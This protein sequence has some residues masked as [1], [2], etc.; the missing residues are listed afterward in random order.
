MRDR[1]P[2]FDEEDL[3]KTLTEGWRIEPVILEYAPVGFGDYHW[4]A[5]SAAG[6]RWFVKV[7]DLTQ[8]SHC[9]P[10]PVS[11]AIGLERAMDTAAEL[12]LRP[13]LAFVAGPVRGVDGRSV[14]PSGPR[15]AVSVF[16]HLDA[17]PGSFDR[18]RTA[19]ELSDV[20]DVLAALHDAEPVA[21]TPEQRFELTRRDTVLASLE[22]TSADWPDAGPFTAAARGLLADHREGVRRALAEFDRIAVTMPT[23]PAELV[24]THGEPHPGNLLRDQGPVDSRGPA[25]YHLIDWDTVG[26]AVPE[27]DLAGIDAAP[28]HLDRY[29]AATGHRVD[30]SLIRGYHL[31]WDLEEVGIYVDQ[32]RNDHDRSAD[33]ELAWDGLVESIGRLAAQPAGH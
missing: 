10:D 12:A 19:A 33:T 2:D 25:G 24:I 14:R 6:D 21:G 28:E 22:S 5:S 26:L 15:Y 17:E 32:L 29:R 4:T 1:P 13:E 7:A 27:R 9:G 8:K 11:A 16:P 31:R 20:I 23:E 18:K 30:R 3:I